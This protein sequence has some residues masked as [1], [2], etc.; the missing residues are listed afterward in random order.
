[1]LNLLKIYKAIIYREDVTDE[2]NSA[3][4]RSIKESREKSES[5]LPNGLSHDAPGKLDK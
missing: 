2:Q 3:G 5:P 1:M 4:R